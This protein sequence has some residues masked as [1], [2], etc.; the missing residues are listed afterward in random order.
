[1]RKYKLFYLNIILVLLPIVLNAK[2]F[3]NFPD[4]IKRKTPNSKYEILSFYQNLKDIKK[5]VVN[6]A[7]TKKIP[8]ATSLEEFMLKEF[9]GIPPK[10]KK[11]Q[12][13]SLGS[14]VIISKN[15]YIITNHHVINKADEI[16]VTI[17]SEKKTYKAKLIG[18]DAQT[19]IAVIKIKAN[20]LPYAKFGNSKILKVGDIVFAI[21]NP[22]GLGESVSMGIISALN[23]TKI[24]IN[25]YENFIQTDASINPGNSGGALVD[26]RGALIGI[27]SA[28]YSKSGGNN[29]IG[30]TIPSNMVKA[31]A[32]KLIIYGYIKRGVLGI[33]VIDLNNKLKKFYKHNQGVVVVNTIK[34]FPA[35][36]AGLKRGDLILKIDDDTIKNSTDFKNKMA[37][38]QIGDKLTIV[39][40][41][42]HNLYKTDLVVTSPYRTYRYNRYNYFYK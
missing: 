21:G 12:I 11:R 13:Y 16:F 35:Y 40:E 14:G 29:G 20:N 32:K 18:S 25:K 28:I 19:D 33:S 3:E 15:G 36:K 6:I 41:R 24:G 9:Y 1:M 31:I 34:G 22:F 8:I 38:Y 39:F 30:F 26:S 4:P 2:I 5:A 10:Y 17:E 27:N 23:K 7:T 37:T 42:N